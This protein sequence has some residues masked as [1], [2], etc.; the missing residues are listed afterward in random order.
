MRVLIVNTSERTGGAAVAANRLMEALNNNGVKARMLVRDKETT[1]PA[2][3]GIGSGWR[4]QLPFLWER[5]CIWVR[6]R[7]KRQR[8]FEVDIANAGLDITRTRAFREA[9][10]IHLHWVNQG[11]LSLRGIRRILDS[12]K[13]V[14]WTM[15][16]AWPS[17]AI[18]HLTFDCRRYEQRCCHCPL[19]PGG[20]SES[21][22]AAQTWRRKEQMLHNRSIR[23]VACSQWLAEAARH[24]ALLSG[25]SVGQ[26]PNP[27]D[28]RL[29]RPLPDRRKARIDAGLPEDGRII[30]F[31]SQRA[32]N[33][34]KGMDY[35]V[36]A[37]RL[38]AAEHPELLADTT[39]GILGGHSEEVV[40]QL[41]FRAVALGYVNDEH[42]IVGIYNAA[43]VFVLPSLSENLPNTIM[44]AMA[45][46]V[47]S[48]AF[49][50]GGIPEEIDHR[51][52]GY[53]ADYRDA[54]DLARGLHWVLCEAD[55]DTLRRQCLSKV[56][57]SYSQQSVALRYIEEYE[58]AMRPQER[59]KQ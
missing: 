16:D 33:P 5:L 55:R 10:V 45:C 24:S 9:D 15:H 2:V 53:I 38:L 14:V 46:G 59:K 51:Q 4:A 34:Y 28:T 8:L 21:D 12:G 35:L 50:V 44:E 17:T 37:C 20:G 29:Y 19:L 47:A 11:M 27:I 43:D 57:R 13:P 52:T 56:A 54:A 36:E 6:L 49:R 25:Q 42:R 3:I 39:L 48:V 58:R 1:H 32:T 18:C 26:I 31:V 7:F 40:G 22:V 41:P 30:L 23:F